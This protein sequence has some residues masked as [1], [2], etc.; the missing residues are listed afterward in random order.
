M[1][2]TVSNLFDLL[3][4]VWTQDRLERQFY[5]ENRFLDKIEKSNKYT[6][7]RQAQVPIEK[8]L[9]GG[10]T[11]KT[12]A[13]G[14]LNAADSLHVDRADY[15]LTYHWQQVELETG[16][17]N[18]ADGVGV[19]STVDAADQTIESNIA[20][21]RREVGRQSVSNQDGLI[22]AC[23]TGGASTT[24][25]LLT[26]GYG[27]DAISRGWLRPG[28]AVDIGTTSDADT[29]VAAS[30][31]T[32]VKEDATDPDITIG[33]SVSTTSGTH[34]VSLA[35]SRSASTGASI[36][37]NGL[38]Q[39]AGSNTLAVGG[40]DA[41]TAGEEFWKPAEV[42]TTT[43]IVSLDL[44]LRLQR[45]VYQKTGKWPTYVT[46]SPKQCADLY[47]LFQSQ[48][49]FSGDGTTSAG[50]VEGFTWNGMK[51]V[52]DPDIPDRELYMLTL[53]DFIVITG[54]KFGK[55]TWASE[56]E[57]GGGKFAWKQGNTS[58]VDAVVYP[59]QL[60]VKRRNSHAAAIGLTG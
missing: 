2:E 15:T 23:D 7:G 51:I 34:F 11:V 47:A 13:G 46:T 49:R 35:G 41:D 30:V 59:I 10:Y 14:A 56:I 17:L 26:T 32:A 6:I 50:S 8:S 27:Y 36:E 22:A 53:E 43:T 39:I 52:C 19:H 31:I 60:G 18:Q 40:L 5:N 28:V 24:V 38:R 33:S 57:G 29:V 4:E 3:K 42:D 20:A 55:P 37:M 44:L 21:L 58:F 54:G 16:A 1:A 9:P 25:E 12:A 48:V 45:K